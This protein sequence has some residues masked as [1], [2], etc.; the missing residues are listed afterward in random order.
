MMIQSIHPWKNEEVV[1][2]KLHKRKPHLLKL[3]Q[4]SSLKKFEALAQKKPMSMSLLVQPQVFQKP[5]KSQKE[6]WTNRLACMCWSSIRRSCRS[7]SFL[8]RIIGIYRSSFACT[9][10]IKTESRELSVCTSL[11]I[12]MRWLKG[13]LEL[14]SKSPRRTTWR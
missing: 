9:R 1:L 12:T 5:Q 4:L 8:W 3:H 11:R 14:R 6:L 10:R 7:L 2:L 13:P